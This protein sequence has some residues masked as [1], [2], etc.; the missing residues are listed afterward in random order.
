[1]SF[2]VYIVRCSDGSYYVGHTDNLE[3]RLAAHRAG[4]MPDCYTHDRR[5]VNLVFSDEFRTRDEAFQRERQVKGWSRAKKEALINGKMRRLE[6][7]SRNM[8]LSR[9]FGR[10]SRF[11]TVLRQAQDE[12]RSFPTLVGR[13]CRLLA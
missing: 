1:M 11:K 3:H 9:G 12:R 6:V 7:L 8:L 4:S 5:P 13:R 2:F 10:L